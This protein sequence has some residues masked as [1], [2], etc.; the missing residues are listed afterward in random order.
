MRRLGCQ[1]PG[2]GILQGKRYELLGIRFSPSVAAFFGMHPALYL[3]AG[4]SS[5][6]ASISMALRIQYPDHESRFADDR[7]G[8]RKE[9]Q[10]A[11]YPALDKSYN[12]QVFSTNA[13][14]QLSDGRQYM[15]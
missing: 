3:Q 5:Q 2:A 14:F 12:L 9:E 15:K 10:N 1:V 13:L 6:I 7:F 8:L 11:G 4:C